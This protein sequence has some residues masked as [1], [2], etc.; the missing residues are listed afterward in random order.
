MKIRPY[1]RIVIEG[2]DGSGKTTLVNQLMEHYGDSAHLVPGY[3]RQPDPKPKIDQWWME[4]LSKNPHGKVVIHDRFFYPEFVYGPVL[5]GFVTGDESTISYVQ[6]FLRANAFL[7][8]CRPP[9]EVL[10]KGIEVEVQMEGVKNMFND[11]LVAYDHMIIREG[12]HYQGRFVKYDWSDDKA[13]LRLIMRLT[14]YI[15]E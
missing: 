12:P 4:Q 14:G 9:I 11:L 13:M 5:R 3:N 6:E 1:R 8:Y 2:M 10:K 15:F 7:I